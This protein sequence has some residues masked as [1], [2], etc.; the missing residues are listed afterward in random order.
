[1]LPI[2]AWTRNALVGLAFSWGVA[3]VQASSDTPLKLVVGFSAGRGVDTTARLVAQ[4]LTAILDRPVIVE[5][6]PGA[7]SMIA[8]DAVARAEPDGSTLLFAGTAMITAP[9]VQGDAAYHPVES[10]APVAGVAQSGLTIAVPSDSEWHSVG[11]MVAA[12]RAK[13]GEITYATTGIGSLHHLAIE[14][15]SQE[16]GIDMLHVP[17]KG[18]S[19]AATDVAAGMVASGVSSL[20]AIKPHL[21]AERVR[22]I[23]MLSAER[24]PTMPELPVVAETVDGVDAAS[25]LFIL[26][27][28]GTPADVRQRLSEAID[29]ALASPQVEEGL[30]TQYAWP[31]YLSTE[32][33]GTWV[34]EEYAVW[35]QVVEAAGLEG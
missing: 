29:Q 23:A 27:P 32:E 1:M 4:E 5:N 25:A 30:A 21:E 34:A 3:S 28:A 31:A 8:A 24:D 6:R 19:R 9:I 33:L 12:A 10:F 16:A 20:A 22:L 26:A 11:D 13:P 35:Q 14:R 17:Y 2:A 18:G 7:A 15:L